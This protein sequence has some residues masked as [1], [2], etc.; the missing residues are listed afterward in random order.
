MENANG[1]LRKKKDS[2]TK[3]TVVRLEL[4]PKMHAKLRVIAAKAGVPMSQYVREVVEQ[5]IEKTD[6]FQ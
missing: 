6:K 1:K 3:L 5:K 2:H 4:E